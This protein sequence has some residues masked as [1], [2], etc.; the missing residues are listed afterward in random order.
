[1]SSAAATSFTCTPG[2]LLNFTAVALNRS[3]Y[4]SILRGLAFATT[5]LQPVRPRCQLNRGNLVPQILVSVFLGGAILWFFFGSPLIWRLMNH[6]VPVVRGMIFVTSVAG[7]V[8]GM[9]TL[10]PYVH[11]LVAYQPNP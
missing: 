6:R 2:K 5:H 3:P 9:Y 1:M 10:V 7:A 8:W 11:R 4:F